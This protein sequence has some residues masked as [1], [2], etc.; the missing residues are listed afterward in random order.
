MVSN[1]D[2]SWDLS[3]DL[4][5]IPSGNLLQFAIEHGPVEIVDLPF[6]NGDLGEGLLFY[7]H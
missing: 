5:D 7:P 3:W 4:L 6:Q 2:F 1:G